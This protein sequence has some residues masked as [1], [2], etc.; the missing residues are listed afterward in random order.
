MAL[1]EWMHPGCLPIGVDIGAG[2]VRM[3]QLRRR[4]L[5]LSL[6]RAARAELPPALRDPESAERT[7][8]IAQTIGRLLDSGGFIGRSCILSVDDRTL[9][10]RSVRQPKIPDDELNRAVQLDAP[11]RLGFAENESAQFG[12]LRAGETRQG[13]DL[14]EEIIVVGA[15]R[16]PIEDLVFSLAAHG[17]RPL[18]IEP[19]FLG[20]ARSFGRLLR[21]AADQ[22]IVRAIVNIGLCTTG[23]I[24]MRGRTVT[25]FK[26]LEFGGEH[27]TR[28]AA[29]RLG[30]EPAAVV[31]MRRRRAAGA[32]PGDPRVDR[33]M[34][35]AVRPLLCD[36]AQEVSLCVRY[37]GVTFRGAR[38]EACLVVGGEARE[39]RLTEQMSEILHLPA[40][41]GQ[42]LH[43]V[44]IP[45]EKGAD[46]LAPGDH[47]EWA[48]AAGLG[49]RLLEQ[50]VWA[51]TD[52][53]RGDPAEET[54]AAGATEERQAA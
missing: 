14:R 50:R 44:A 33:A 13:D 28:A 10:V 34:F 38:P 45:P 9:R 21:R 3:I 51:K 29:E 49:L 12:W 32:A 24:L 36:L 26:Q 37:C 18:A 40:T 11:G 41:V 52:R 5:G 30:L 35:E 39:P 20:C 1:R 31:E 43:G 16:K 8:A 4:R 42:P 48:V 54:D 7:D 47:A 53:R 22:T 25:F 17:A 2:S 23:V 6:V 46:E 19:G 15:R 27:M